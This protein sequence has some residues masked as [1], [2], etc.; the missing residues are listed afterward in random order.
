MRRFDKKHNIAKVNLLAE[1]RYL[2]SKGI[3]TEEERDFNR[4]AQAAGFSPSAYREYINQNTQHKPIVY[5]EKNEYSPIETINIISNELYNRGL[6]PKEF[7][8]VDG[9]YLSRSRD[10]ETAPL[11]HIHRVRDEISKIEQ[12]YKETGKG[13]HWSTCRTY[14]DRY[15]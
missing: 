14:W 4:D 7:P 3:L 8:P 2:K 10:G 5:P 9:E 11:V 6:F 1:Q 13:L 12:E 15:W